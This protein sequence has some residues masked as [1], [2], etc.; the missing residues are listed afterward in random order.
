MMD[1]LGQKSLVGDGQMVK[2]ARQMFV[3]NFGHFVTSALNDARNYVQQNMRKAVFKHMTIAKKKSAFPNLSDIKAIIRR[4]LDL[5]NPKK[6]DIAILW[7]DKLLPPCTGNRYDFPDKVRYYETISEGKSNP[8]NEYPDITAETEAFGF[9]VFE[10]NH[11]K[12]P[13]LWELERNHKGP[14]TRTKVMKEPKENHVKDP[15]CRYF[16]ISEHKELAPIYTK[17]DAGQEKYGG[18]TEKGVRRFMAVTETL[19]QIR[20]TPQAIAWEREL[21]AKMRERKGIIGRTYEEQKRL[22]SKKPT[23]TAKSAASITSAELFDAEEKEPDPDA[24]FDEYGATVEEE[25]TEE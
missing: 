25:V 19:K 16:Y 8:N 11:H 21:L 3:A 18:W 10:S 1:N 17:P 4:K 24:D 14:G 15:E 13:K 20:G 7:V 6:L 5:N 9:V 22:K 23:N 2:T 12:W